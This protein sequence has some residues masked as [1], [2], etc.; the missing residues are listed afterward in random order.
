MVPY[1][2]CGLSRVL[3]IRLASSAPSPLG[4]AFEFLSSVLVSYIPNTPTNPNLRTV[5]VNHFTFFISFR[6]FFASSSEK[7]S[8]RVQM[9]S[10]TRLVIRAYSF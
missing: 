5:Y 1:P 7:F 9:R 8:P 2:L 3:L 6:S 10:K 4:K